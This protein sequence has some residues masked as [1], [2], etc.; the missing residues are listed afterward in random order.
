MGSPLETPR[1]AMS[2]L[3][4]CLTM[5]NVPFVIENDKLRLEKSFCQTYVKTSENM[6]EMSEFKPTCIEAGLGLTLDGNR[7][8]VNSSQ[9]QITTVGTLTSVV[10]TGQLS[11]TNT[12]ESV[13]TNTGSLVINGG[14]GIQRQLNG[15]IG[16]FEELFIKGKRVLTEEDLH[17][18]AL[19]PSKSFSS[20]AAVVRAVKNLQLD[21]GNLVNMVVTNDVPS[22]D[23]HE[24]CVDLQQDVANIASYYK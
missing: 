16:Y 14:M 5:S 17:R 20:E 22:Q 6:S 24:L 1:Q 9:P 3:K 13:S 12:T 8:S 11:I 19:G 10:T 18:E 2:A 23:I 15:N 7:L 4:R 21:V